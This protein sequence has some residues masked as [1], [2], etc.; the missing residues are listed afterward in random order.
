MHPIL[1][2]FRMKEPFDLF[3]WT[4][5]WSNSFKADLSSWICMKALLLQ[6][7]SQQLNK[8]KLNY[9]WS[10][11]EST[12]LKFESDFWRHFRVS[13]H[14][15]LNMQGG[16]PGARGGRLSRFSSRTSLCFV[17]LTLWDY[18]TH[19][20]SHTIRLTLLTVLCLVSTLLYNCEPVL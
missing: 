13:C 14:A 18:L 2:R 9:H 3:G 12:K 7:T 20:A 17:V 10:P 1:C 8:A 4:A 19:G 5:C 16:R 6:R 15:R 11:L